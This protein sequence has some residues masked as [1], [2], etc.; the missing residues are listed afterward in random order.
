MS[1]KSKISCG[2]KTINRNTNFT[3]TFMEFEITISDGLHWGYK[4]FKGEYVGSHRNSI[5][6]V[7][8]CLA[9]FTAHAVMR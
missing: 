4:Y 1:R 7:I 2:R 9:N 5:L 6:Y 8:I 3:S